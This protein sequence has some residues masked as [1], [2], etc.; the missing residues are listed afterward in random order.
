M[1]FRAWDKIAKAIVGLDA[2]EFTDRLEGRSGANCFLCSEWKGKK[3]NRSYWRDMRDLELMQF[4]GC[5]DKNGK[6]IYE[7]DI[8]Q[9]VERYIDLE[10]PMADA[11][12]RIRQ[13][14]ITY[15]HQGFWIHSEADGWKG[16]SIY[17]WNNLEVVGNIYENADLYEKI[18]TK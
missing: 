3:E 17:D 12:S 6:D 1:K 8:V 7:G 9:E 5:Q 18:T 15:W 11:G 2:I 14:Y 4:T 10:N 13:S 16:E